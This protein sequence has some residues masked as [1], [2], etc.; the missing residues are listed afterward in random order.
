MKQFNCTEQVIDEQICML[1]NGN[2]YNFSKRTC[3]HSSGW[4]S[5]IYEPNVTSL[6]SKW[7]RHPP[8]SYDLI[9][10]GLI[11]NISGKIGLLEVSR[12]FFCWVYLGHN[13]GSTNMHI[14]RTLLAW[15]PRALFFRR[16]VVMNCTTQI[17]VGG[18]MDI[19]NF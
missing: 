9:L 2:I 6:V 15:V 4:N 19:R 11:W 16:F 3:L 10:I 12:N 1:M 5:V 14:I 13:M 17:P 7:R 8:A 18:A